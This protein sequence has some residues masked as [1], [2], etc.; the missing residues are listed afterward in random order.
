ML[1]YEVLQKAL[2]D[3][4][5]GNNEMLPKQVGCFLIDT[6]DTFF[7]LK[8]AYTVY[9]APERFSTYLQAVSITVHGAS[10][11]TQLLSQNQKSLRTE[12]NFEIFYDHVLK[13][14]SSL[15]EEPVLPQPRSCQGGSMMGEVLV[16][17]LVQR[18]N[19][20]MHTLKHWN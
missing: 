7:S 19:T 10:S 16:N 20:G 3:T 17:T 14:S 6:F 13:E 11:G 9:S 18:T 1:N 12:E 5:T 4:Q 15:A 2:D 8:L